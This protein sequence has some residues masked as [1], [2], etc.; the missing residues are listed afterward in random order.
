MET[1]STGYVFVK[2]LQENLQVVVQGAFYLKAEYELNRG[3][4]QDPHAGHQH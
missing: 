2:G 3:A 1:D 4:E